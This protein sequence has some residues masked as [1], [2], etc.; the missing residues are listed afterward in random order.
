[1]KDFFWEGLC[2]CWLGSYS[3]FKWEERELCLSF[4][5]THF[6]QGNAEKSDKG[7]REEGMC[8]EGSDKCWALMM[9]C[10]SVRSK[11]LRDR[12]FIKK[13]LC[14]SS[15]FLQTSNTAP[16]TG[17]LQTFARLGT[18][19]LQPT[20]VLCK[21]LRTST[22]QILCKELPCCHSNRT[23]RTSRSSCFSH[24]SK[25]GVLHHIINQLCVQLSWCGHPGTGM[26]VEFH[27]VQGSFPYF[28][29]F[30]KVPQKK[31]V[32]VSKLGIT[33][34]TWNRGTERGAKPTKIRQ[35]DKDFDLTKS[36]NRTLIPTGFKR[37]PV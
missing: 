30:L 12:A 2:V 3:E 8:W 16:D 26:P 22:Q 15:G 11:I 5:S 32:P 7:E 29:C 18:F 10:L 14:L 33:V 9:L 37:T 23:G 21:L 17:G 35:K 4:I 6:S 1:M 28:F 27:L 13:W 36:L 31:S 24:N 34:L 25:P 19:G 20:S